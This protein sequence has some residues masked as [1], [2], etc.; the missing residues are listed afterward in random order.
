M[1]EHSAGQAVADAFTNVE[2]T[3]LTLDA[4]GHLA[5]FK[6][7]AL[8][9]FPSGIQVGNFVRTKL[10]YAALVSNTSQMKG[11]PV[12]DDWTSFIN[13]PKVWE[14][15][16]AYVD[17][18]GSSVAFMVL[19]AMYQTFGEE[20][21]KQIYTGL[22]STR[23]EVSMNTP[24]SVTKLVSGE[25]P[26]MMYILTNHVGDALRKGAPLEFTIPTSG[27]VPFYFAAGVLKNAKHP[28][29]AR[30]YL[31]Y[32]LDQGQ[33]VIIS[34]GEYSMRN[35]APAP[36]GLPP[37]DK[38]KFINFD[39]KKALADQK[40]L[41]AWWQ[42]VTHPKEP[43][44]HRHAAAG[45]AMRLIRRYGLF[46]LAAAAMVLIVV[47][48][49]AIVVVQ[50]FI[51]AQR[52][53]WD[54]TLDHVTLVVTR[55]HW[56]ALLNTL[57]I[58]LGATTFA[59]A[60]GIPMAWLFARTNLPGKGLLEKLAT[61]PIFIPPFV[62]A[63][64]WILLAAPRIGAFNYPFGRCGAG[65]PE[66]LHADR[67]LLGDRHLPGAVRDDDR[68]GRVAQHGPELGGGGAGLRAQ[69]LAD[70]RYGHPAACRARDPFR[71]GAGL[72]HHDR[73]VW[74]ARG[75]RVGAAALFHHLAHLFGLA[76]SAARVRRHGR[77]CHL[78][79]P[80]VAAGHDAAAVADQ[81]TI[82]RYRFRQGLPG[83]ADS[84]RAGSM[85]R[86]RLR[87]ALLLL[88]R[89]RAWSPSFSGSG[90]STLPGFGP[91][92]SENVADIGTSSRDVRITLQ[93]SL[94]DFDC[95]GFASTSVGPRDLLERAARTDPPSAAADPGISAHSRPGLDFRVSP[96]ASA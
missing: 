63:V 12:P 17:P 7:D 57:V 85:A 37:L 11:L 48:P 78:P 76:G 47:V 3:L 55:W 93:N 34:R 45:P 5:E 2:D 92:T 41:I 84:P 70:G 18:R 87:L 8:K 9:D 86:R 96:S 50:G 95:L 13:A 44:A 24:A 40:K 73:T 29:A 79:D 88:H 30:L 68:G 51:S 14:D 62:G 72:H 90:L 65:A 80:A 53:S 36:K 20:K 58:G 21:A 42:D 6:S 77:A 66:R 25:R 64:A 4:G 15:R 83:P 69:P 38:V 19:A 91:F 67:H 23:P 26:L 31:E 52:G 32:L 28:N 46:G 39:L 82:I 81:G 89:G 61:I 43:T 59:C 49:L 35:N 74:N 94:L 56:A 33:D 16:V 22:K 75:D 10:G 60:A 71:C 1:S 27:A 54:F